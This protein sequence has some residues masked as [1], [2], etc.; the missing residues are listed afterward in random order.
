MNPCVES[1]FKCWGE[2]DKLVR[3]LYLTPS[4]CTLFEIQKTC[5][6]PSCVLGTGALRPNEKLHTSILTP[7]CIMTKHRLREGN[8][9]PQE[10]YFHHIS[11]K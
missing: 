3:R 5:A 11:R 10:V 2:G 6:C 9:L 1:K 7:F 8:N 4:C